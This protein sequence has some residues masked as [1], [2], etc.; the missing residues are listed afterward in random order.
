MNKRTL[1]LLEKAFE[2]QVNAALNGGTDLIQTKSKLA[3]QLVEDGLLVKDTQMLPGWPSAITIEGYRLT[4]LGHATYCFS[5]R[6]DGEPD[7]DLI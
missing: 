5:D 6:C 3:Q 1:D 7:K 4:D 2:A